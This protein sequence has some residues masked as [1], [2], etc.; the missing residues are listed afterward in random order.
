MKTVLRLG[1]LFRAFRPL[2]W[3][4]V[5]TAAVAVLLLAQLAYG[6]AVEKGPP[7]VVI[8]TADG[9]YVYPL[10]QDRLLTFGGPIG[11]TVVRIAAKSVQ[12]VSDPGPR[13]ICVTQGAITASGSWLAC[14]PNKV[15]IKIDGQPDPSAVDAKTY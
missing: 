14:L 8:Q 1:N 13:Q 6:G 4:A 12:V 9:N 10:D 5:G 15:F 11:N 2:D 3:V 7:S